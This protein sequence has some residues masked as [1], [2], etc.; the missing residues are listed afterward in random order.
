LLIDEVDK[1][2]LIF[3]DGRPA[4]RKIGDR[5]IDSLL[6]VRGEQQQA[7]S[8]SL[9]FDVKSPLQALRAA[10]A[11]PAQVPIAE[12]PK[13][14]VG[15]LINCS[16]PD[17]VVTD[18]KLQSASPLSLSMLVIT[19]RSDSRKVKLRFCRDVVLAERETGNPHMPRQAV[20]HD[21]DRVD[22]SLAG[23]EAVRLH[24]TLGG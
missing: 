5:F 16:T 2:T 3:T 15:W 1:Q 24:V 6:V 20:T 19:G 8:M 13:T 11:P 9:G 4:H 21:G 22:L 17:I 23:H 7:S 10:I 18:L 12:M 14:S